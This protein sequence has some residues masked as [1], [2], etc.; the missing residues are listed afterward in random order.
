LNLAKE[1][2]HETWHALPDR[3]PQVVPDDFVIMPNHVHGILALVGAGLAPPDAAAVKSNLSRQCSLPA[4]IGAFKS[5]STIKIN[6]LLKR[7]G[8]LFWQR[9]Y[10]EHIIRNGEDMK[11]AQ[12]YFGKPL[13]MVPKPRVSGIT[14]PLILRGLGS[15][16]AKSGRGKPRPYSPANSISFPRV[17]TIQ[18]L[19]FK[20]ANS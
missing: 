8:Q 17:I 16:K 4:V 6:R 7:S 20:C 1:V 11:N 2:A 9:G 15:S 5:I 19:V 14:E 3:F 13:E 18:A 12:R 10:Y